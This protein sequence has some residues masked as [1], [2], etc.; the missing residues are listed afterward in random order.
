MKL[1]RATF[2]RIVGKLCLIVLLLFI[3]LL[4][5]FHLS[6]ALLLYTEVYAKLH[7]LCVMA[8]RR[9]KRLANIDPEIVEA[10]FECFFCKLRGF[11]C[12]TNVIRM[13]CCSAFC[14]KTCQDTWAKTWN[15]CGRCRLPLATDLEGTEEQQGNE[16]R[17]TDER[18]QIAPANHPVEQASRE[19]FIQ[20][21][22][23]ISGT[24]GIEKLLSFKPTGYTETVGEYFHIQNS[25]DFQQKLAL[26]CAHLQGFEL[27]KIFLLIRFDKP[28]MFRLYFENLK[29]L[30][31][32]FFR[33]FTTLLSGID[34][35]VFNRQIVSML[36]A[37]G[38]RCVN[39]EL[40]VHG[41]KFNTTV[42]EL[43]T[44]MYSP[45]GCFSV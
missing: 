18:F 20:L 41:A 23:L 10:E 25:S 3:F 38:H 43:P 7:A 5:S 8:L 13:E 17:S 2:I 45:Y 27:E 31:F 28:R 9:S 32:P 33:I 6:A 44:L 40:T 19:Q 21:R 39:F 24:Q 15:Q 4:H 35:S 1:H 11:T 36:S 22:R 12:L 29:L 26:L 16:T 14:H 42:P 34:L 37:T 30:L